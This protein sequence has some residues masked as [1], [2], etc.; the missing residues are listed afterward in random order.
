MKTQA[1]RMLDTLG[2]AYQVREYPVD[3]DRLDAV[4]VAEAIGLPVQSVFKSLVVSGESKRPV[5]ALIPGDAQLDIKRLGKLVGQKRM[6][7]VPVSRLPE[8]TGYVR[9]GV[10]PL[11]TKH[12]FPV[13]IHETVLDLPQVSISA[14]KR[15]GQILLR[16]QDLVAATNATV[17][18]LVEDG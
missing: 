7:L 8:I 4:Y 18:Y 12:R 9:G 13:C 15:G 10:S 17:A 14:G 1:M 2:V 5:V 11:A 16:G 3:E 6:S